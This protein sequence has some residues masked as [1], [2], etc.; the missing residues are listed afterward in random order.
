[1]HPSDLELVGVGQARNAIILNL[2]DEEVSLIANE[3]APKRILSAS[4]NPHTPRSTPLPMWDF[5]DLP[6]SFNLLALVMYEA[7]SKLQGAPPPPHTHTSPFISTEDVHCL[8]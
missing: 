8:S 7:P 5:E 2:N 4:K 1:M 3:A 6:V